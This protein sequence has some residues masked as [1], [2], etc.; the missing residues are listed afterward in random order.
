LRGMKTEG[1]LRFPI[2]LGNL[3]GKKTLYIVLRDR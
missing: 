1:L 2:W 3:S